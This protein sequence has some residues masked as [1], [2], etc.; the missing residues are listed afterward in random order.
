MIHILRL[1]LGNVR[2]VSASAIVSSL[3][4]YSKTLDVLKSFQVPL[5]IYSCRLQ[6]NRH[7][8]GKCL[9]PMTWK[10]LAGIF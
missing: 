9:T 8:Q 3:C 6:K 2:A 7:S 4:G 1:G 10:K 5:Q